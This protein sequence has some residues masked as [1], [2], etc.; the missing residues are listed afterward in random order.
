MI[1][2]FVSNNMKIINKTEWNTK[3]FGAFIRRIAKEEN[4]TAAE[5][6]KLSVSIV[7][8]KRSSRW[9]D[10]HPTGWALYDG[11]L[12][13]IKV[14]KGVDIDKSALAHTIAHEMGHLQGVRHGAALR[15]PRYGWG[16][17]DGKG[18][19]DVWEWASV[20]TLTRKV[21]KK[22]KLRGREL[23]SQKIEHCQRQ[24]VVWQK[25]MKF[26]QNKMR[27]WNRKCRYYEG[28]MAALAPEQEDEK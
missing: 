16:K 15:T 20:L 10:D 7:Y 9:R 24:L 18:W 2:G 4:L 11:T 8:R 13:C 28:R 27:V 23:A 5:L 6:K 21:V 12:M 17:I 3:Q 19:R 14:V 26:A 22:E 25:K 1:H